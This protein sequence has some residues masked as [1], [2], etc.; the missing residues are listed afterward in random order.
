MVWLYEN[1]IFDDNSVNYYGFVYQIK[2]LLTGK[3][4]FG[5]KQFTF[6]K[7]KVIKG[8]KKRIV[9]E[10]D[11]REYY[12]SSESLQSDINVQGKE[13]FERTIL[14]FCT[15]K[16]ELSYYEAKIQFEHDV[17]LYPDKFYNSWISVKVSGKNLR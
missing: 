15:S 8:K 11:W 13:N 12:G 5:K 7:T 2:N 3:L 16:S 14:K 10:S 17:L 4:Y 1:Q 6:R 9:V